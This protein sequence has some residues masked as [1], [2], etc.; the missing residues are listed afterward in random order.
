[1]LGRQLITNQRIYLGVLIASIVISVF[2]L[3]SLFGRHLYLELTT[4]FRLQYALGASV[5]ALLLIGFQ[6]WKFLPLLICCAV[7]NWVLIAPYYSAPARPADLPSGI[8]LKLMLANVLKSNQNYAAVTAAVSH[9]QPDIVVL[10]EFTET[11]QNNLKHFAALYPY[12]KLAP[13]AGGSGM[14]LF[15]RYAIEEADILELDA[16]GHPALH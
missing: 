3:T 14:A 1:M 12:A 7:L 4:H 15:S 13:K 9:E 16:S 5:C 2:T 10:Q 8:H 6:S 11:W